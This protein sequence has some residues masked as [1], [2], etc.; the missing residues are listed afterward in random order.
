MVG[1]ERLRA[2]SKL[3][4]SAQKALHGLDRDQRAQRADDFTRL[5][6]A[7][8]YLSL[9]LERTEPE[10]LSDAVHAELTRLLEQIASNTSSVAANPVNFADALIGQAAQLPV[11]QQRDFEQAGRDAAT[12]F[13]RSASQHQNALQEEMSALKQQLEDISGGST[14]SLEATKT[15]GEA[16]A[17]ELRGRLEAMQASASAASE[18]VAK[19]VERQQGA[20][21]E[22]QALREKRVEEQWSEIRSRVDTQAGDLVDD[23]SR[24]RSEAA[25]LVGAVSAASTANHFRDDAKGERKAYWVLLT[26]TLLFLGAAVVFAGLAASESEAEVRQLLAKLGVS[27]ALLGLGVFTGAQARDHRGRDKGSRDKELDMRAFGPFIEP[28]PPKEQVRERILMTRRS[29]GRVEPSAPE[30]TDEDIDLLSSEDE[31]E[32]AARDMRQRHKA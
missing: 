15:S 30:Q 22:E 28:L 31:I 17:Q 25:G 29:F 23:L 1:E 27:G 12:S 5:E 13:R 6:A 11:A 26:V 19:L 2:L 21:L 32:I 16:L 4:E 10:L 24:M 9:V 8:G 20:F 7:L 3:L 18:E 14:R